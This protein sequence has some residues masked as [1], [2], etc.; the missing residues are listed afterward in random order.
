MSRLKRFEEQ[1]DCLLIAHFDQGCFLPEMHIPHIS[2][3][4]GFDPDTQSVKM[5]DVDNNLTSPYQVSF[6]VFYRGLST[7]YN[8]VF[9]HYGYAEGGYVFVRME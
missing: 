3:V 8:A 4:G 5:L 7:N 1:G 9:R 2:P 6:D